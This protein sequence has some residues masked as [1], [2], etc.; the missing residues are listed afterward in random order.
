MGATASYQ[1]A[2][3]IVN[4]TLSIINKSNQQCVDTLSTNQRIDILNASGDVVIHD[5]N[6]DQTASL[7]S[8]C[9]LS[10]AVQ[11]SIDEDITKLASQMSSTTTSPLPLDWSV[12]VS[13]KINSDVTN[14]CKKVVNIYTAKCL[15]DLNA[16]QSVTIGNAKNVTIYSLQWDQVSKSV[17]TCVLQNIMKTDEA[18]T[19]MSDVTQYSKKQTDNTLWIIIGVI[20]G[21]GIITAILCCAFGVIPQCKEA[22]EKQK[23]QSKTNITGGKKT[24]ITGG[25]ID[26]LTRSTFG[27]RSRSTF[28]GFPKIK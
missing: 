27:S 8:T 3:N 2:E 7:D 14:L 22:M 11:T 4:E 26:P 24:N 23:M 6:W 1:S 9:T 21:V 25:Y 10:S 12:E 19:Y 20:V 5:I 18:L 16:D 28:G 13:A 17:N 15:S